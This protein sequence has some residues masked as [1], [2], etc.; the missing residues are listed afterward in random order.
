MDGPSVVY[1]GNT[2]KLLR[3]S[4]FKRRKNQKKEQT[5]EEDEKK[6]ISTTSPRSAKSP[7]ADQRKH[8]FTR[9]LEW[10]DCIP[11]LKKSRKQA[12]GQFVR[13]FKKLENRKGVW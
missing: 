9:V 1:K 10:S 13:L 8:S 6:P 12:A 7:N 5:P 4:T 3:P 2:E 11:Y